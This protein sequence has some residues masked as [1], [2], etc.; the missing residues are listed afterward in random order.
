MRRGNYLKLETICVL[1]QHSPIRNYLK[2]FEV[3]NY[4][5]P[6]A[7]Q[8]FSSFGYTHTHTDRRALPGAVNTTPLKHKREQEI[9]VEKTIPQKSLSFIPILSFYISGAQILLSL[10]PLPVCKTGLPRDSQWEYTAPVSTWVRDIC[11]PSLQ[12]CIRD[13]II[14]HYYSIRR[15]LQEKKK[16]LL[17]KLCA[18]K[19]HV[20]LIF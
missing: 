3:R 16:V 2:L 20:V 18:G 4:L 19:C 5:W 15:F 8:P 12:F 7:T 11:L 1:L 13:S 14:I 6:P 9:D 10:G 17:H